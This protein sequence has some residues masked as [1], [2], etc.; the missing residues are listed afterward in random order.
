M[1]RGVLRFSKNLAAANQTE[2]NH[3]TMEQNLEFSEYHGVAYYM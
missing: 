1:H 3:W 2:P